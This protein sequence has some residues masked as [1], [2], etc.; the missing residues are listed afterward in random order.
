[1]PVNLSGPAQSDPA[2]LFH[3]R[4]GRQVTQTLWHKSNRNAVI[5]RYYSLLTYRPKGKKTEL[6]KDDKAGESCV[7][8]NEG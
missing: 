5:T 2:R 3:L 1:M 6:N 7:T 8:G 4:R